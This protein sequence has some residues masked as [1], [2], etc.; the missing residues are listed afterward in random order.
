MSLSEMLKAIPELSKEDEAVL[1][2][3][4]SQM[5]YMADLSNT[6]SSWTAP[7]AKGR[8]LSSPTRSPPA[9]RPP[10]SAT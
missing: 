9:V 4:G 1:L 10:T 6:I 2:R 8:A 3:V 5:Q 7:S